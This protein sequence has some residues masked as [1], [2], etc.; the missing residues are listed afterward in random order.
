MSPG[1]APP[2]ATVRLVADDRRS[3]RWARREAP[4]QL[5]GRGG[6]KVEFGQGSWTQTKNDRWS[7]QPSEVTMLLVTVWVFPFA[8]PET[9]TRAL[10][11]LPPRAPPS[12][13]G[14]PFTSSAPQT[15]LQTVRRAGSSAPPDE[16][17]RQ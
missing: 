8:P 4:L 6:D 1:V 15:L 11:C 2:A 7:V 12:H 5:K 3:E 13:E 14:V 17:F 9:P 16:V 10:D